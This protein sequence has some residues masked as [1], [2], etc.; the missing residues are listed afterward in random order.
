MAKKITD[1]PVWIT[2]I[3][4]CYDSTHLGDRDLADCHALSMAS[5]RA[6]K[7][8]GISD[9]IRQIDVAEISEMYS[10]QELLWS[11]GLGLCG[12]GEGGKLIDSGRTNMGA[13]L[14]VNPSGGVLSGNPVTVAGL[15]RIAEAALQLRSEAGEHQV[16]DAGIA[17]AHG[18]SGICGQMHC[19]VVL[20]KD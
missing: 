17:L 12:P 20:A 4:S 6:Y 7:I 8:A 9:P 19:V 5:Q 3:G 10:Y 14:P 15:T 1:R 13:E 2:G 18:T 16:P 11:E